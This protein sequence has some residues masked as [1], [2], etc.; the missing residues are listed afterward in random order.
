MKENEK[1]FICDCGYNFEESESWNCWK[2]INETVKCPKCFQQY[3]VRYDT[4][5]IDECDHVDCSD[6]FWLEK[7]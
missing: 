1:L 4:V 3:I 2:L 5:D 7:K 6:K